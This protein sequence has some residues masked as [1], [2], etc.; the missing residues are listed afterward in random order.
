LE[1]YI[2][3]IDLQ[4]VSNQ[5]LAFIGDAVYNV[6]I[7]TYL[8][9]KSNMQTGILHRQ[10]IKYVSAKA[11]CKIIDAILESLSEEEVNIYKRGRNTNITTVSKNVDIVEYKKA[12][13]FEALI[14]ELYLQKKIDRLE[15]IINMSI[16][17]IDTNN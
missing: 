4:I 3:K 13:G 11:Q 5:T 9:S 16:K 8:A 15:E 7:R 12:T 17:V 10:S 6:Y 2:S 1:E 14:G